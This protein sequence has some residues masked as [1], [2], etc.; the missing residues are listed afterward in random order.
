MDVEYGGDKFVTYPPMAE[1]I[2]G[3]VG[4]PPQRTIVSLS[5]KELE[6]LTRESAIG[7]GY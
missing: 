1:P 2:S 7:R 5:F 3:E 6:I 4:P